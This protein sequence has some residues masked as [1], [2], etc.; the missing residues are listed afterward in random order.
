[1]I[2]SLKREVQD[3]VP[4]A[5]AELV[6]AALEAEASAAV[7]EATVSSQREKNQTKYKR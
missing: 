6:E 2:C 7:V 4:A 3:P 5:M 1:M